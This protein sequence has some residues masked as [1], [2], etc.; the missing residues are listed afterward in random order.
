MR[1]A[2]R[3]LYFASADSFYD[4]SCTR[5]AAGRRHQRTVWQARGF[6]MALTVPLIAIA[7]QRNPSWSLKV[8][9]SRDIAFYATSV[10]AVGVYLL[11]MAF[12]G[13]VVQLIGGSW[14]AIA[15]IVFFAAAIGLLA[16]LVA[17]AALRR[18]VRVF[19]VK[20]FY[21]HKY[22]YREEWLRFIDTLTGATS[23]ESPQVAA[24]RAIAQIIGSPRAALLMRADA[25]GEWRMEAAWPGGEVLPVTRE[26]PARRSRTR[27]FLE[28]RQ[29]VIDV[30]GMAATRTVRGVARPEWL[31]RSALATCRAGA[32]RKR[33]IGLLTLAEPPDGFQLPSRT[34][35]F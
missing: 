21:R 28:R 17:S 19:L 16:M 29:W 6:I 13:Y 27:E 3:Y 32:A 4:V 33:L 11:L 30:A 20:H 31:H 22:D 15:Q 23:D 10:A 8:F 25:P 35:I 18:R 26:R 2:L 1:W 14:G 12:G 7:A 34:V 9:V 5:R 24:V